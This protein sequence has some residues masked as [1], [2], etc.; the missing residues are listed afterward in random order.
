M[1]A[2]VRKAEGGKRR[3]MEEEA[4]SRDSG[5]PLFMEEL[6]ETEGGEVVAPRG[7]LWLSSDDLYDEY[8][9]MR[10]GSG[11]HVEMAKALVALHAAPQASRKRRI[12]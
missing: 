5:T 12:L 2:I 7:V 8:G 1:K 6:W 11:A 10:A 3:A 4:S 9:T